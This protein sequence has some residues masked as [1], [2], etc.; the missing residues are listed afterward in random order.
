MRAFVF[1]LILANLLFL[2]WTQGYFGAS[3]DP[4]ALRVQQ[5]LL[6]DQV[7]VVARDEFP[8]EPGAKPE[9]LVKTEE[10]KPED[11]CLLV[12][13]LPAA[14][15]ARVEGLLA[16]KWPA[17]KAVRTVAEASASYWVFI[18]PLDTKQ[19]VDKKT[20]ELK[21]FNVPE[22]FVVQDSGPNN[23]AISLG[24][25]S[26]KEAATA[27]LEVLRAKGIKSA[28]VAERTSKPTSISLDITGPETQADAIRQS[29]A[30][31]LPESKLVAC[32]VAASSAQ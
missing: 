3:S 16:E 23:R 17:F 1:L 30:D 29:L 22:F 21:K 7:K 10:K 11:V 31:L 2:A 20:A 9:K 19:D 12:A 32:K 5:Q 6:A 26:S 15:A 14:D 4:D 25:F 28:K 13:E 8:A 27:R 18:P 24:L